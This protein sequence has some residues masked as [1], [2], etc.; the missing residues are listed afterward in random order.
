MPSLHGREGDLP[1]LGE[2]RRVAEKVDQ[3]LAQ[4]GL[5][6]MGDAEIVREI[7]D[8][9]IAL[10]GHEGVH[11]G[12]HFPHHLAHGKG[13]GIDLHPLGF[14]LREVEDVVDQAEEMTGIRLDLAHVCEQ[15]LLAE[16]LH[17]LLQH[18]GIADHRRERRAQLVAHIGQ[19]L[20]FRAVGFFRRFLGGFQRLLGLLARGDVGMGAD[21]FADR[22]RL[23]E[24]GDAAHGHVAPHA[25]MAAQAVLDLVE[26]DVGDRM[27]PG[28]LRL[29]AVVGVDRREEAVAGGLLRRLAGEA[30]PFGRRD[31]EA[32]IRRSR[33]DDGGGSLGE[34]AEALLALARALL[35]ELAQGLVGDDETDAVHRPV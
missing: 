12:G 17:L 18:L 31:R 10:L 21:P 4:L 33:P 13:F 15:A 19:E 2:F 26:R 22:P 8:E 32:A 11:G 14:D 6:G 29:L 27:I 35:G 3:A 28:E 7:E 34:R 24:D 25:V 20:A 23:V 5:V 16:I 1:V 9:G 30:G